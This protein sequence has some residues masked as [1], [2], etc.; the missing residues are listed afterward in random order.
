[1]VEA[2]LA[3]TEGGL[4]IT[5]STTRARDILAVASYMYGDYIGSRR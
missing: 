4:I 1:M 3:S 2:D 5:T